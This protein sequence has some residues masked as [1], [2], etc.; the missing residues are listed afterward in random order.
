LTF[1]VRPCESHEELADALN[2]ISHYFADR[3]TL[4]DAARLAQ[5]MPLDRM[6][7]AFDGDRI[8][9]GAGV[10]PFE[11]SVPGWTAVPSAGVTVIGVLPT[12][13]RRG[14]LR[15]MMRAQLD[16][17]HARGE[18]VAWL[19]ASEGVI[20]PRYG[21]GLASTIGSMNLPRERTAYARP[22]VPR[23]SLRFVEPDEALELFPPIQQAA[24]RERPGMFRRSREWWET[25]RLADDPARRAPGRGPLN[26]LLLEVDG[27]PEAYALYRMSSA[28]EHGSASGSVH[29]V[30]ALARTSSGLGEIWR[31]LLD[32]DWTAWIKSD[33]LPL[34][35][36]LF[37]L[38]EE[39]RRMRV[40]LNDGVWVRLV[41]VG[42]AL[43]ARG[44]GTDEPFVVDVR[45]EFCPWN[46]G[47]WQLAGGRAERTSAAPDVALDVGDLGSVYLGGF[48]WRELQAA[49]RVEERRAGAVA[50]AERVFGTWPK[51]WCPEIF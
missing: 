48:T 6:H 1:E 46:A 26:R 34:D 18:C 33:Y 37:L 31:A 7:A 27:E 24:M 32:M 36:P 2:P 35:H 50:Q 13:R 11:L 15:A 42:A 12:H 44:Y 4:D 47:P 3:V 51:P 21:Y 39:P 30:E 22:F 23:G 45:D 41:D 29:V 5:W 40:E 8:V 38:L 43:S 28:F 10:F 14:I 16:D 9:G 20:Y 49:G 25:R 19:W 17:V